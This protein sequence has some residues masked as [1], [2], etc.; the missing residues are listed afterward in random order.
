M[1]NFPPCLEVTAWQQSRCQAEIAGD[2]RGWRAERVGRSGAASRLCGMAAPHAWSRRPPRVPLRR[3]GEVGLADSKND[4]PW[5]L[6]LGGEPARI[7]DRRWRL[8]SWARKRP[9][10]GGGATQLPAPATQRGLSW[11]PESRDREHDSRGRARRW[12]CRSRATKTRTDRALR[13]R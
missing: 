3:A 10:A 12:R 1:A 4:E 9:F 13:A 8:G 11:P 2:S 6:P 7:I 5:S